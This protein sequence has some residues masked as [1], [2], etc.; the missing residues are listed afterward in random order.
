MKTEKK[1]TA[2]TVAEFIGKTFESDLP[3]R[4]IDALRPFDGKN[5]T[6]RILAA[7]P[8]L[9][10][11]ATWRLRR[12]YGWTSLQTSTYCTPQGYADG[13]SLDLILA[14]SE[15]SVPLNLEYV[16]GNVPLGNNSYGEN[17]A[18]FS[19]RRERNANR[20][21][22]QSNAELCG[23]AAAILNRYAAAVAE[24]EKARAEF[25]KLA[26][27]GTPLDPVKWDFLRAVDPNDKA[28]H[29]KSK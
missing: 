11:G 28:T 22:A 6:T 13:T 2:A 9:P 15:S 23:K 10:N 5:I 25:E 20:A 27:H 26:E 24:M 4:V 29:T 1:F 7:L 16:A 14:R 19:A 8:A 12:Q 21:T 18:Y 3:D 17:C